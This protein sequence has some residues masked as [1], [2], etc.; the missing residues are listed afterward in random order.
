MVKGNCSSDWHLSICE[1]QNLSICCR[2]YG[3]WVQEIE[4]WHNNKHRQRAIFKFKFQQ[5]SNV[6]DHN[7]WKPSSWSLLSYEDI[8]WRDR[9]SRYVQ[10]K[11]SILVS[12]KYWA[13]ISE[14]NTEWNYFE[15]SWN[16]VMIYWNNVILGFLIKW[17]SAVSVPT[18]ASVP[19][20]AWAPPQQLRFQLPSLTCKR[21][22]C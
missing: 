15:I 21:F 2:T 18:S 13:R 5:Q 14:I 11:V 7:S 10:N 17:L 3:S 12:V 22:S 9:S 20:G 8:K 19:T 6:C 1:K 16:W 4:I